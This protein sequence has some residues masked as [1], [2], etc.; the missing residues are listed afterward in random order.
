MT[1]ARILSATTRELVARFTQLSLEQHRALRRN[2]IDTY[3]LLADELIAAQEEIHRRGL[4]AGQDFLPL[5]QHSD[6]N[7]RLNA[8]INYLRVDARL[9][10]PV[11]EALR[12]EDEFHIKINAYRVL[13]RWRKG[14][15]PPK[16]ESAAG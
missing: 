13:Q 15:F 2:D 7:V 3:N 10:V 11:L 16:D 12:Q 8:A 5:L 14:E 9:A 6:S 4:E 1:P